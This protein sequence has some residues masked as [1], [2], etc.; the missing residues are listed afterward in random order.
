MAPPVTMIGP[1]A[2]NGLPVPIATTADSGL[3]TAARGEMRACFWVT[4]S[5]VSGMPCPRITGDHRASRATT[6]APT[7]ATTT[8]RGLGRSVE[9][10]GSSR[11]YDDRR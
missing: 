4:A 6:N 10:E 7:V 1:S 2:P 3:A 9:S 8:I 5:I 11:G